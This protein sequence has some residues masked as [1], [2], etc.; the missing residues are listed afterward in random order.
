MRKNLMRRAVAIGAAV[1][2]VLIGAM[3]AAD[4][5]HGGHAGGGH[6]DGHMGGHMGG[7]AFKSGSI[8]VDAGSIGKS[9]GNSANSF[10][11]SSGGNPGKFKDANHGRHYA[12]SG[13]WPGNDNGHHRGKHNYYR[14]YG[15]YPWYGLYS[16]S[17]GGGCSWLYRKAVATGS[18][19]WWN[20]Y[21]QCT[22]S[23]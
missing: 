22:G 16:Y 12:Y 19:Y 1:C 5:G 11:Y 23:Y 9:H 21:Y 6:M 7:N 15:L 4:A 10:R 14:H 13:N 2:L 8:H 20:R 17:Y 18:D 3:S